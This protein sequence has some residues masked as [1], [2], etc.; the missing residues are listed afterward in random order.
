MS[1]SRR[2]ARGAEACGLDAAGVAAGP[3]RDGDRARRVGGDVVPEDAGGEDEDMADVWAGIDEER[4]RVRRRDRRANEVGGWAATSTV[5]A[6]GS[7]IYKDLLF[8]W[9]TRRRNANCEALSRQDCV[10]FSMESVR[11]H[12]YAAAVR[13]RLP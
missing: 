10:C 13:V 4:V 1:R 7:G 5:M 2:R 8:K 6:A 9:I 3:V 12:L 11:L